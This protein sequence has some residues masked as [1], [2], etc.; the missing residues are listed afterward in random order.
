MIAGLEKELLRLQKGD[1]KK[2]KVKAHEAY[3]YRD[4]ERVKKVPLTKLPIK[5]EIGDTLEV[6]TEAGGV[7]LVTVTEK[8]LTH[9]TLD[10]N[11]PL[12]GQDLVFDVEILDIRDSTPKER[13]QGFAP[14]G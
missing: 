12:A 5:V 2:V 10:G 14:G 9:V 3:G 8:T 11:H 7:E 13:A 4:E 1:K 6:E